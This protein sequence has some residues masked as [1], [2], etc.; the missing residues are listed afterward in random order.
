[1]VYGY[2]RVSTDM[3]DC[4]NQKRGFKIRVRADV[5]SKKNV[6]LANGVSYYPYKDKIHDA[7]IQQFIQ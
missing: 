6:N 7:K 2:I 3:Q 1:M 4:Q 5:C